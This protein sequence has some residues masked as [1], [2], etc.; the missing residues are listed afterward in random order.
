[1]QTTTFTNSPAKT[2]TMSELPAELQ[3]R[4]RIIEKVADGL[5]RAED[6]QSE[7]VGV[8]KLIRD[9]IVGGKTDRQRLKRELV[10]QTTLSSPNLALPIVT[11]DTEDHVWLFR[12]WIEGRSLRDKINTEGKLTVPEA[13]AITSQLAGALDELHRAGLLHRDVKPEHIILRDD[14]KA[15]VVDAALAARLRTENVFEVV[16]TP[17]Y[18]SPEQAKGKLVSFRSDLYAIGC[19]LFE[20]VTGDAP[21]SGSMNELLKAHADQDAPDAPSSLPEPVQ[22]VFT[23]LLSKDPR[24][25]P[26]SAQQVRRALNEFVPEELQSGTP[27]TLGSA[28]GKPP[29]P[30][31]KRKKPPA[32]PSRRP[33]TSNGEV[34]AVV[35][36]GAAASVAAAGVAASA[37]SAEQIDAAV[38]EAAPA[39]EKI[40]DQVDV[41]AVVAKAEAE[42]LSLQN[43]VPDEPVSQAPMSAM[44][45]AQ[46]DVTQPLDALDIEEVE[47]ILENA[48]RPAEEP[49]E[50]LAHFGADSA[51]APTVPFAP[52]MELQIAASAPVIPPTQAMPSVQNGTSGALGLDSVAPSVSELDYEDDAPTIARDVA[53]SAAL[54]GMSPQVQSPFPSAAIEPVG[55]VSAPAPA[56]PT[57]LSAPV[58]QTAVETKVLSSVQ[59]KKKSKLPIILLLGAMLF[60]GMLIL[61]GGAYWWF[62]QSSEDLVASV[63]PTTN[64]PAA[65]GDVKPPAVNPSAPVAAAAAPAAPA[66]A[67]PAVAA[68]AVVPAAPA[69]VPAPAEPAAPPVAEPVVAA[70]APEPAEPRERASS[71]TG[72]RDRRATRSTME[73][74]SAMSS[75]SGSR[76][77]QVRAEAR[78]HFQ[79]R[80]YPQAVAAYQRATSLA[81][82]NAGVFGGLGASHLAMRN[83]RGAI[84][85]Y[86]RAV[87]LS[88][89]HS[90]Y[91]TSL[92]H[93]Y[94]QQG[95]RANARRS[96]QRAI[97]LN[98]NNTSA[99]RSL[100]SL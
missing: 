85:A 29:T 13:L 55:P 66:V 92:G 71:M 78:E 88:P 63:T 91:F 57:N 27:V 70:A 79:A 97:A 100:A 10:K 94:R 83:S 76:L 19:V 46:A 9:E 22:S 11:G 81:P 1:M 68:P 69:V 26:F 4:F 37:V 86:T 28:S 72:S 51:N 61:A 14:G 60:G 30:P 64:A 17:N 6:S 40:H 75:M 95:D 62:T 31:S 59:P 36:G 33:K 47:S 20:M 56:T 87:E 89:R 52:G 3:E 48:S 45:K 82:R 44:E 25:R 41:A 73:R 5:F 12:D 38:L 93:A 90:G 39:T 96:Y 43:A 8:L 58:A 35:T 80:R 23:S 67:A 53:L 74:S 65:V 32:P 7:R 99:Q 2:Q 15:V 21:Y 98:P 42:M 34:A 18:V 54:D 77:D 50:E 16:G 84:A 49:E 24:K